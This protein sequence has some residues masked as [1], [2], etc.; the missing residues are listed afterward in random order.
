M[1]ETKRFLS[2]TGGA[3]D[4]SALQET[5]RSKDGDAIDGTKVKQ[6]RIAGDD[7]RSLGCYGAG[8]DM[9]VIRVGYGYIRQGGYG[10][11]A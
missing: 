1:V 8:N 5:S 11:H 10:N 7:E 6:V 9:Q 2:A 4:V 3:G